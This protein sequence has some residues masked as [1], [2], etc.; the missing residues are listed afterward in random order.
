MTWEELK[1]KA[2]EMGAL[3][4]CGGTILFSHL[5]FHEDGD[6]YLDREELDDVWNIPC[7][8]SDK[9]PDE[10]LAIMKALQ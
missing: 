4:C 10:M 1:E 3:V 5:E 8:S 2:K 9:T 6:I 7:V